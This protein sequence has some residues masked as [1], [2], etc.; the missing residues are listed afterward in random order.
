MSY[1][2]FIYSNKSVSIIYCLRSDHL[3]VH[4]YITLLHAWL[5]GPGQL[6]AVPGPG[7]EDAAGAG[8]VAVGEH[9]AP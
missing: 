8:G 3:N 4:I 7:V 2:I 1:F 5:P 6:A 9:G